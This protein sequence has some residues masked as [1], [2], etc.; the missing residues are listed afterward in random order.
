MHIIYLMFHSSCRAYLSLA[1]E[2][3]HVLHDHKVTAGAH[4]KR[5]HAL[6]T[7]NQQTVSHIHLSALQRG[8][9]VSVSIVD[10]Q[11]FLVYGSG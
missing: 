6:D 4:I 1:W 5:A 10:V 8:F 7:I 9:Y 3:T 2:A 11:V